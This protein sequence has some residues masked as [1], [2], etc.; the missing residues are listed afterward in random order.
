[1]ST[2]CNKPAVH[3]LLGMINFLAPHIPKM[4]SITT[5]LHDL[6]KDDIY[7]QCKADTALKQIKS[8]LCTEPILQFFDSSLQSMIQADANYHG[9][10][11]YLLQRGKSVAYASRSLSPAESNYAQI[12]KELLVIVFACKKFHQYIYSCSTDVH[13]DHK[14]LES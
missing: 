11:V 1:M 13:T 3:C 8:I 10:R 12:E 6:I 7:F 2:F 5:P 9:L 14:P 4:A